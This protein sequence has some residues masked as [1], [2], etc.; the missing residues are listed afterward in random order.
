MLTKAVIDSPAIEP[1][2]GLCLTIDGGGTTFVDF[3]HNRT[4]QQKKENRLISFLVVLAI[5]VAASGDLHAADR[6]ADNFA[7]PPASAKPWVYWY[8]MDGNMTRDGITADLEAMKQAGIGGAIFLDVNIGIPRGP[9]E[10]MSPEWKSLFKHAVAEADRLG[11]QIALAAGP[12][13]CGTGGPWIKPEQSM[14]HLVASE[15]NFLNGSL[16]FNGVLPRPEPREPFFGKRTLTPELA[17]E[18]KD[19]YHDVAV[20]AFPT[21]GDSRIVDVDEKALYYRPPF[22]SRPGVKPFLPSL[23]QYPELPPDQCIAADKVIDLTGRLSADGHLDWNVPPGKWTILRFGST[24][25]GQTTRP[26]PSAGLGFESDKF[27]PAALDA[28]FAAFIEPLVK[29]VAQF[30]HQ[31]SGLTTVHFDSWE[32]SSQNWSGKFRQEFRKRRGYDPLRFLPAMTGRVVGNEEMSERFLWDLRQTAQELVIENH[33]SQLKQLAHQQG[34]VLSLEPYDL[35]PCADLELGA[36]ADVPMGEFWAHGFH[37]EFSCIEAVSIGHTMGRP[38]V[39]AESFTSDAGEAWKLSPDSVKNQADW[40][41]CCGIN[42]LVIHC[43]QHQPRLDQ[44]PGMTM[45]PHGVHWERTQ[46]WWSLVPAFHTY[47]SR[48]QQMLRR[49]MPVAD[50]LYLTPEGAPQVFL[51]PRSATVGKLPDRRGYNFDGCAPSTLLER[52]SVKDGRIVFPDGMSY[53]VLVLPEVETMSPRLLEKIQKLLRAGATVLGVPPLKSPSLSDYPDCDQQVSRM[54]NALWNE[55][56]IGR[57]KLISDVVPEPQ[58]VEAT[59]QVNNPEIYPSY[60]STAAVL[61]K[62][63]VP[64]DF[65]SDGSLRY[66]H[67]RDGDSNIYFVANRE[68]RSVAVQ[69]SFRITGRMP[70]WWNPVTGERYDLPR[71]EQRNG[72]TLVPL[73]FEAH[74]SAFIV[75]RKSAVESVVAG[76]NFPEVRVLKTLEIPWQVSFDPKWGAPEKVI[77]P[78][79]EDWS[80]N[81][82]PGIKFYSGKAIYRTSFDLDGSVVSNARDRIL[83]SLGDVKNLAS[84][85]FNGCDLGVVWCPPWRLRIPGGLLRNQKN[86]LEITVAN[87]WPNRLIGD[88]SL[89]DDKKFCHTTWNPYKTNSPLL[90]SGLIGPVAILEELQTE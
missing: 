80:T 64:P 67:R 43:Y 56:A 35:N 19:Y 5:L 87:L 72:L 90:P 14:Q 85:R 68:N 60:E 47:L 30:H 70:E 20:L 57:G 23:S 50:I 15:T 84:I 25:T 4:R 8:F 76:E 6:L 22:T 58:S 7:H 59:K 36:V 38:I 66:I 11:L 89:P 71:Y 2:T 55:H 54:A 18:W 24:T 62:M 26:A 10:F 51:P 48:C 9:V 88:Q 45:G 49:G 29:A 61:A 31:G 27:D 44:W 73:R 16:H 17:E 65:E 40:A 53:R 1:A 75:F 63:G 21:E 12:G 52:A 81:S 46:T 82:A 28:H 69:C 77:F 41:L 39:A 13:W 42:R 79:L 86:E 83:L 78:K 32:M 34:M 37:S 33:V 74:E 3:L